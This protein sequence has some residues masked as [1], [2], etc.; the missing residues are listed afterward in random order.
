M[1]STAHTLDEA[2]VERAAHGLRLLLPR[3]P[4]RGKVGEVRAASVG[5][6]MEIHDFRQYQPGDDLR[7]IDW[8]AVARTGELIL[9]VRQDEVSPRIEVLVDG[10]RSM[11][12]T[13]SKA[14]RA[15]EVSL[16][17]TRIASRQGLD[18]MMIVAGGRA[19]RVGA[20]G[21]SALLR[22]TAF[23]GRDG[24]D[25]AL[26]RGPPLRPCGLRVAVSDFLFETDFPRFVERLGHGAAALVLLQLLDPEDLSP[27]GGYGAQLLDVESGESRERILSP[28]VL[29]AYQRR[30]DEHQRLLRAAAGRVRALL[31]T[32]SA[33]MP[34]DQLTRGPLAGMWGAAA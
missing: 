5:A 17:L 1:S 12:I 24:F 6:S 9:R 21:A 8:N 18:P 4:H 23:D 13:E 22:A 11:A 10:S 2:A 32:A 25:A 3:G 30:L 34:L 26:R 33:G 7:Q 19:E 16:L 31:L 14:A 15:R 28:S 20:S 27:T 29:R